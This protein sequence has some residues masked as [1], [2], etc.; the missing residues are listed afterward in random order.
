MLAA[1][2]LTCGC[3]LIIPALLRLAAMFLVYVCGTT[4]FYNNMESVGAFSILVGL[5]LL[6]FARYAWRRT[7]KLLRDRSFVLN[8]Q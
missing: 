3:C 1:W 6:A 2:F 5:L 8:A 7:E 4:E